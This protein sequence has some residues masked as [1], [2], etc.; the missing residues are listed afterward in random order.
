MLLCMGSSDAYDT[1]P[2]IDLFKFVTFIL[3]PEN[4]FHIIKATRLAVVKQVIKTESE[5]QELYQK[6]KLPVD[7]ARDSFLRNRKLLEE[8]QSLGSEFN[9]NIEPRLAYSDSQLPPFYDY[10]YVDESR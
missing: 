9:S 8:C 7:L 10:L 5:L 1:D 4:K 6:N 2:V 3:G